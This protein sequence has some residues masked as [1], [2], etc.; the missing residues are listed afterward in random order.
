MTLED[1]AEILLAFR[2]LDLA[3]NAIRT[4]MAEMEGRIRADIR[5][6]D[7]RVEDIERQQRTASRIGAFDPRTIGPYQF[8]RGRIPSPVTQ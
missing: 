4:E 2:A 7:A 8:F 3:L 5:S 6:L 1:R